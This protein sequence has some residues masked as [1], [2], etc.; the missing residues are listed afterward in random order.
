MRFNQC[1]GSLGEPTCAT[2]VKA[3]EE[4][5]RPITLAVRVE[6]QAPGVAG[7]DLHSGVS[8]RGL[9]SIVTKR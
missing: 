2:V 3:S 4:R 7:V 6:R 9:I 5:D 1:K 8:L